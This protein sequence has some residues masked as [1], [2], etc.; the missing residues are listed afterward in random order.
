[1]Q[2]EMTPYG[3]YLYS[4]GKFKPHSYEFVDD[5]IV[6]KTAASTETQEAAH[7]SGVSANN[8]KKKDNDKEKYPKTK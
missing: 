7:T 3:R 4:I 5:D 8:Y 1:M 2:I 6:Y